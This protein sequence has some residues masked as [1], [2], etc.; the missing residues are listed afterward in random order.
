M[1]PGPLHII[2]QLGRRRLQHRDAVRQRHRLPRRLGG[3]RRCHRRLCAVG[4]AEM[5]GLGFLF[6]NPPGGG[7]CLV[8]RLP[9]RVL[10]E[11]GVWTRPLEGVV[12]T[13]PP[14]Q[15]KFLVQSA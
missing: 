11:R 12:Q 2:A 7:G 14:V 3:P 8:G 13:T 10:N 9:I 6:P 4:V 1:P 5:E 15:K